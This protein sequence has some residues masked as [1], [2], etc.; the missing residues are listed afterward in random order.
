MS[1]DQ[2]IDRLQRIPPLV[3]LLLLAAVL[4]LWNI[5]GDPLW[6]D[7]AFSLWFSDHSYL[8]LW[9]ETPK[10]ETHPPLFYS[11]LK[12]WRGVLGSSD[13]ALRLPSALASIAI[14]AVVYAAGRSLGGTAHG[15]T[16]G[17]LAGLLAALW[18]MQIE[19][20]HDARP[21]A[22]M[23]LAAAMIVAGALP[24]LMQPLAAARP[25]HRLPR[26]APALLAAYGLLAAGMALSLWSHNLGTIPVAVAGGF[27]A[28]WWASVGGRSVAL[29]VNL[30]LTALVAATLYAPNVPTLLMQIGTVS[31]GF[32]LPAPT[33][34]QLVWLGIRMLSQPAPF[35]LNIMIG[36]PLLAVVLLLGLVGLVRLTRQAGARDL[37]PALFVAMMLGGPL[38]IMV[39]L[40]YTVQPVLL[41]RTLLMLQ[42]PLFLLMAGLAWLGPVWTMRPVAVALV[43]ATAI[44]T[45][46]PTPVTFTFA[47]PY[48]AIVEHIA[49]S[50][51]PDAPVVGL[52]AAELPVFYTAV[53]RGIDLNVVQLTQPYRLADGDSFGPLATR[54]VMTTREELVQAVGAARTV[55]YVYRTPEFHDPDGSVPQMLRDAG[56][57]ETV[58]LPYDQTDAGFSRF[59]RA[60]RCPPA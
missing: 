5:G 1:A 56:F 53:R 46:R 54:V 43:L 52:A 21:Y 6:M 27:L 42:P 40:T 44:G 30:A 28:V 38:L 20:A 58:I 12:A 8:Y 18:R 11:M 50:D 10:Y 13:A 31:K 7:E 32:W 39:G 33:L 45:P 17:L 14:V 35:T 22:F 26:E 15:R 4:R 16:A 47:R 24:L 29:F 55:W 57:C 51:R 48:R 60:E 41:P 3:G 25:L 9:T 19:F 59:D 36:A 37:A 49:A 23:A 34:P 2:L